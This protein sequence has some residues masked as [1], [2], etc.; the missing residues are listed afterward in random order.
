M[1]LIDLHLRQESHRETGQFVDGR[2][3]N[4]VVG[5]PVLVGFARASR[6]PLER[7]GD[8]EIDQIELPADRMIASKWSAS[9][10]HQAHA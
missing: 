5:H 2:E 1:V 4:A 8:L 3:T 7:P 6:V 9:T 10:W